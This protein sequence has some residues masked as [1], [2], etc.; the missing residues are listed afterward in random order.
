MLFA[1]DHWEINI[2]GVS[3]WSYFRFDHNELPASV[4]QA[5]IKFNFKDVLYFFKLMLLRFS[6]T[7]TVVFLAARKDLMSL[8]KSAPFSDKKVTLFLREDGHKVQ[9]NVFFIE[10]F[11]YLF[12]K[13]SAGIFKQT[14]KELEQQLL[15]KSIDI[16]KHQNNIKAAV[17]DYYFNKILAFL[18]KGKKVY[19]SNCVIPKIERTVASYNSVEIQHGVIHASHPD[20]ANM[21]SDIFNIPLLCWGD[22]WQEKIK[23]IGFLGQVIVGSSPEVLNATTEH[24]NSICFFTTLSDEVSEKI[25]TSI[26][27][28]KEF[29]IVLQGHPRDLFKYNIEVFGNVTV[30]EG[31]SPLEV[32]CPIMH[33]STLIYV[34]VKNNKQFIYLATNSELKSEI[35]NRLSDK[36]D[37]TYEK[38]YYVA[39][40]SDEVVKILH[41]LR[42]SD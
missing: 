12:R 40:S 41:C 24:Q 30:S 1:P 8:L 15:S 11:R 5:K 25:V 10:V 32:K 38:D 22:F 6:N 19:F 31:L 21:P 42:A 37:A 35:V 39:Y 29:D 28:L 26:S 14:Y 4:Y 18:L 33:D 3:V 13:F 9:G 34:S 23:R 7:E 2:K 17:G 16:A 27:K 36:Y 20:Y